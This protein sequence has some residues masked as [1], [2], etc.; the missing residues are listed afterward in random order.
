MTEPNLDKNL[1]FPHKQLC[2]DV[3]IENKDLFYIYSLMGLDK[4]II[5]Y[6]QSRK[7][8]LSSPPKFP[9]VLLQPVLALDSL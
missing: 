9:D 4:C 1:F 5:L 2:C 6:V 8:I 3:L 7:R